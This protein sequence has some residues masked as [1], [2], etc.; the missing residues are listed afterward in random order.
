MSPET[1]NF[2]KWYR[3]NQEEGITMQA[4][5]PPVDRV[6]TMSTPLAGQPATF[7]LPYAI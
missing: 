1:E 4:E 7:P 5:E 6:W 3:Q 2:M